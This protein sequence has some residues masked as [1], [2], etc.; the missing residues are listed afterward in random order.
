MSRSLVNMNKGMIVVA[1]D[2]KVIVTLV[3]EFLRKK[4]FRVFPAHD[5]MQAMVGVRQQNPKAVILDIGMP[6]GSGM[7]VLKKLKSMN[8]TSQIPVLILTGAIDPKMELT[9]KGLGADEF[10]MKPVNL[11]QLYDALA[12]VLGLPPEPSEPDATGGSA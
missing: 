2:D 9:A 1:D 12:R 5:S 11:H 7:D 3:S 8:T 4:G 10:L 6:G